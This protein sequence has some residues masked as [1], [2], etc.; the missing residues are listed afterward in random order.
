MATIR[1][2]G[3][4]AGRQ[5]P[6]VMHFYWTIESFPELQPLDPWVRHAAWRACRLRPLRAWQVWAAFL[7]QFGV[8]LAGAFLGLILDGRLAALTAN[9]QGAPPDAPFPI[10][11]AVFSFVASCVGLFLFLQFYARLLRPHFQRY[12][13]SSSAA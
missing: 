4:A 12:L 13:Q 2:R 5:R 7:G 9:P 11:T 3:A 10:A 1:I 8:V 6:T